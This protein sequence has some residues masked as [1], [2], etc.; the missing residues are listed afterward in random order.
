MEL[1]TSATSTVDVVL[2]AQ[3][4]ERLRARAPAVWRDE[5]VEPH[6]SSAACARSRSF[7]V[8]PSGMVETVVSQ[9]E[10]QRLDGLHFGAVWLVSPPNRS[11]YGSRKRDEAVISEGR[12]V[13]RA[14]GR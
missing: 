12:T 10:M 5:R 3:T 1:L 14:D 13:Y 2:T 8:S 7:L 9:W 6:T 11:G 4:A